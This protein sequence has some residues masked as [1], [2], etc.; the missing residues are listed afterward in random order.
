MA[1]LI[2]APEVKEF[3][4]RVEPFLLAHEAENNLT[5]GIL[6]AISQGRH[7]EAFLASLEED[8]EVI[9]VA[10]QTP[11]HNLV[12][13]IASAE[14][15]KM[16]AEQLDTAWPGVNGEARQ[17]GLFA[18]I[19]S[20]RTGQSF[21]TQMQQ[22]IYAL[23]DVE[24]PVGV[25]GAPRLA[26][27]GDRALLERWF[28]E[29]EREALPT[30]DANANQTARRVEWFLT[31]AD[32]GVMLWEHE[33]TPVSV[34]GHSGPTPNGMRVGPVYT[35]P[36][37]RGRGYA[38]ACVAELSACVL[39]SGRRFCFLYTDLANATSN[40][41]YQRIGYRPVCDAAVY[42]FPDPDA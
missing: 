9:A 20:E 4:A 28:L 16:L 33:G 7:D 42:R 1:R 30:E 21:A 39:A 25:E 38:S 10:I 29:F 40:S 27:E 41:I 12:L 8:G 35:P 26:A 36:G 23:T 31:N 3:R 5:F 6:Y 14:A 22:R 37:Q 2:V 19:W 18:D 32:S 24:R 15:T 13:S 11:P 17:A 34:A